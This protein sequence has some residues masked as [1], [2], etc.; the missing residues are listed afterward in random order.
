MDLKVHFIV[1]MTYCY[2]HSHYAWSGSTLTLRI[3][4]QVC[5]KYLYIIIS[6]YKSIFIP[7]NLCAI[8]S[9][10]PIIEVWDLDL[11]DCLEPAFKL[12]CKPSKKKN[13]KR[14]GHKD[15]VLDLAWNENYTLV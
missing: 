1:I 9:M 3:Q 8:G 15:A 6:L 12:G 5:I 13:K 7:G 10:T 2:H 4:N 11:I 14:V